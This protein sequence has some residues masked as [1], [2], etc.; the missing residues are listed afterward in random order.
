MRLDDAEH[1]LSRC[2]APASFGK[3]LLEGLDVSSWGG[4]VGALITRERPPATTY[5]VPRHLECSLLGYVNVYVHSLGSV[6][7]GRVIIFVLPK[8]SLAAG[9]LALG[10]FLSV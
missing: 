6:A 4:S 10:E 5:L 7:A 9:Q 3:L 2:L 8:A 1:A